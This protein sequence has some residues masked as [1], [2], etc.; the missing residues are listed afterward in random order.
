MRLGPGN[1]C[2]GHTAH[3]HSGD[4]GNRKRPCSSCSVPGQGRRLSRQRR[5]PSGTALE[6]CGATIQDCLSWALLP[7]GFR[8]ASTH[9]HS[10][11]P[12]RLPSVPRE[13]SQIECGPTRDV[14][15]RFL[16]SGFLISE[17]NAATLVAARP[18]AK[19]QSSPIREKARATAAL[20]E[21]RSG[22]GLCGRRN[23]AGSLPTSMQPWA[24]VTTRNLRLDV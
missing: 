1:T 5:L 21:P 20:I 8:L 6:I 18:F 10:I 2:I 23:R 14:G 7:F 24:R 9:D 13:V 17:T 22:F 16:F 11:P 4:S 15:V 12:Y 3:H 19:D